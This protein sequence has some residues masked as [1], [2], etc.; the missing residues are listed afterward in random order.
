MKNNKSMRELMNMMSDEK[1]LNEGKNSFDD[2]IEATE[3]LEKI[4]YQLA[5][6]KLASYLRET[7]SSLGTKTI[8]KLREV[9][10]AMDKLMEEF[11][12]GDMM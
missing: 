2:S 4:E 10:K 3:F 12:M 6:K 5:S 7:D 8:A 11:Y 9:N 1:I